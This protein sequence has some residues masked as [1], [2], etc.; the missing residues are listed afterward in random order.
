MHKKP[1]R[2]V[3]ISAIC[4]DALDGLTYL[5]GQGKIHRDVKAG[6]ILLTENGTVKLG[7]SNV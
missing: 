2:E 5:H 6:N 3:E 4:Q 7:K 1:L